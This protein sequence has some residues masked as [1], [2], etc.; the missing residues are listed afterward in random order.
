MSLSER[1]DGVDRRIQGDRRSGMDRRSGVDRRIIGERRSNLVYLVADS[2]QRQPTPM[3]AQPASIAAPQAPPPLDEREFTLLDA[4]SKVYD[5]ALNPA[6]WPKALAGLGIILRAGA[7]GLAERDAA[8][9]DGRILHW[10][11]KDSRQVGPSQMTKVAFEDS[12]SQPGSVLI[13]DASDSETTFAGGQAWQGWL[14]DE[15]FAG[16]LRG[17]VDNT[18]GVITQILFLR[19]QADSRYCADD[20]S[21]LG[22]LI[23][24][25]QRAVRAGRA[26]RRAQFFHQIAFDALDA[27]PIGV[28]FVDATGEITAANRIARQIIE[29]ENVRAYQETMRRAD[30]TAQLPRLR[31]AVS[32]AMGDLQETGGEAVS[33]FAVPRRPGLRPLTCLLAPLG[34]ST[35]YNESDGPSA[36]LFIGDPDKPMEIDQRR[37]RQL[38]GLSR[39]EARV[40]ALLA[41]GYKLD[42]TAESL[43]L[44]YE[45]VRKHLK[46]VFDKTGCD[47]QAELVRL[48]VTGPATL[49]I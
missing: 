35:E 44:V 49:P 3:P 38:Y 47:R 42:A 1:R 25:I 31:R 14:R 20:A 22:R 11:N 34:A 4:A 45:T 18:D 33:A 32:E 13:E 9:G 28:A 29:G 39:A 2:G 8:T 30:A 17:T 40:V 26:L 16:V 37:L 46:Q 15:G 27:V 21:L 48:L 7:V 6:A 36:M 24:G 23:P 10:F 41:Q 19:E 43:G 12:L 5:A